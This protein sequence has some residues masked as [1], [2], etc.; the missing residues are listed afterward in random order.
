MR[1][2]RGCSTWENSISRTRLSQEMFSS[3]PRCSVPRTSFWNTK[4]KARI[5]SWANIAP[6]CFKSSSPHFMPNQTGCS[7]LLSQ[8]L[9]PW[10]RTFDVIHLWRAC[11][12]LALQNPYFAHFQFHSLLPCWFWVLRIQKGWE[13][14]KR[15]SHW[16]QYICSVCSWIN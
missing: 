14:R 4:I 8:T 9:L 6:G 16:Q 2:G 7:P 11:P 15:K 3:L 5:S 12:R 13:K 10:P 1:I